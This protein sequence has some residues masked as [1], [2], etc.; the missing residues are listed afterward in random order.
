MV[1]ISNDNVLIKKSL[2]ILLSSLQ[3]WY[4][5]NQEEPYIHIKLYNKVSK[6]AYHEFRR[7]LSESIIKKEM[8][9]LGIENE[10]LKKLKVYNDIKLNPI[11]TRKETKIK[12]KVRHR[13]IIK[14]TQVKS[15]SDRTIYEILKVEEVELVPELPDM[16]SVE[17][18]DDVVGKIARSVENDREESKKVWSKMNYWIRPEKEAKLLLKYERQQLNNLKR[19]EQQQLISISNYNQEADIQQEIDIQDM[20][21]D[22]LEDMFDINAI[23]KFYC[24]EVVNE[25][26]ERKRK[27]LDQA[28]NDLDR[29]YNPHL[30][31]D[32]D[33]SC[34][35]TD[36]EFD[37]DNDT[38][39]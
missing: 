1:V 32:D 18:I 15:F 30:Y 25:V 2:G 8:R 26:M 24:Q 29:K 35:D 31:K 33:S 23:P 22:P 39:D 3:V 12:S 21:K 28:V 11:K 27:L 7:N 4:K 38:F 14:D 10:S 36:S 6:E 37:G 13:N 19:V 16:V 5:N 34:F 9:F 20:I 17:I